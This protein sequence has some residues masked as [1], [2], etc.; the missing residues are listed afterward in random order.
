VMAQISGDET[1]WETDPLQ[2][3]AKSGELMAYRHEGFWQPMDTL[4]EKNLLES[5]W[6]SGKAPW[7]V[8]E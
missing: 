6:A 7:K 5:L 4:R 3:L 1:T 2:N 8:W